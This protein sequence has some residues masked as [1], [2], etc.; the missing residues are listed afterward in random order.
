MLLLKRLP[1]KGWVDSGVKDPESVA[2]HSYSL[3]VLAMAEADK[4]GLNSEKA[5]KMALIH[6]LHESFLND[7]TPDIKRRIPRNLIKT[8]EKSIL[9]Q[10]FGEF[11]PKI[12][13]AYLR[14]Y[15]E[16]LKN[17]SPEARLV[18][19]L[20]NDEMVLE[21]SWLNKTQ[22]LDLSRFGLKRHRFIRGRSCSR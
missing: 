15:E 17:G 5:V 1:R 9:N 18:R 16:Y 11:S 4:R 22:G 12:A 8:V 2:D 21:A 10:I 7:L 13:E 20:D 3:A 6:D 14:L 19:R